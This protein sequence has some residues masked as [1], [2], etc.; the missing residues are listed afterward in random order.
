M[1]TYDDN[2]VKNLAGKGGG[3]GG[4]GGEEFS[5]MSSIMILSNA[6]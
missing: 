4:G 1:D 6:A 2:S 3:G 5:G